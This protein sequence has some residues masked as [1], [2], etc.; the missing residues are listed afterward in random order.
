[1]SQDKTPKRQAKISP[2]KGDANLTIPDLRMSPTPLPIGAKD[3]Y[4]AR[5]FEDLENHRKKLMEAMEA[6]DTDVIINDDTDVI[7]DEE[8]VIDLSKGGYYRP[9][10]GTDNKA[11][12]M[13]RREKR[14]K[15]RSKMTLFEDDDNVDG[16]PAAKPRKPKVR[17]A[18][19]PS[20]EELNPLEVMGR[21]NK[22]QR[23]CFTWNNPSIDGKHWPNSWK[24]ARSASGSVPIGSGHQRRGALPGVPGNDQADVHHRLSS[25]D[26]TIQDVRSARQVKQEG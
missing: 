22:C 18:E 7:E 15:E 26:G 5:M 1:M 12:V 8:S 2:F 24:E 14:R 16:I 4:Y 9:S 6:E 23:Y 21:G 10:L 3:D 20:F 19:H 17:L 13:E 25:H 11:E